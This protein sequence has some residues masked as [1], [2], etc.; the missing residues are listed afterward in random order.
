[1]PESVGKKTP[2]QVT[3]LNHALFSKAVEFMEVNDH[4]NHFGRVG[5]G[6]FIDWLEEAHFAQCKHEAW[7]TCGVSRRCV[8]CKEWLPDPDGSIPL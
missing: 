8:D 7:D 5:L 4:Y 3:D 2:R 1:M 6:R